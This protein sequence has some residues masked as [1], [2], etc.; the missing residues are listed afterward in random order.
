M[1]FLQVA[2]ILSCKQWWLAIL[3]RKKKME[4]KEMLN[5]DSLIG[6]V[7]DLKSGSSET[8]L[9]QENWSTPRR[10]DDGEWSIP[11]PR[12]FFPLPIWRRM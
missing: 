2:I 12:T 10:I 1:K 4:G 9:D 3:K 7:Q 5:A 8:S 6:Y 11:F